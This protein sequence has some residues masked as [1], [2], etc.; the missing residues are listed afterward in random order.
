M[1]DKTVPLTLDPNTKYSIQIFPCIRDPTGNKPQTRQGAGRDKVIA[2]TEVGQAGRKQA[3]SITE[4]SP[5]N[6]AGGQAAQM[7]GQ[8]L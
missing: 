4:V 1:K 8:R 2:G 7:I 6:N 3:G 5:S